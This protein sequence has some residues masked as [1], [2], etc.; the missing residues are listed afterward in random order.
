MNGPGGCE[1]CDA[2]E[3]SLYTALAA[4]QAELPH[5]D[6]GNIGGGD[7]KDGKK[8]PKYKYADL[9]DVS[10]AVLPLL[11]KHG[12]AFN[13]KPTMVDGEFGLSYKLV[14]KSGE[15]DEGFVPF[16]RTGSPQQT[17]SLI[18][19]YR[20]YC[21]C[22]IT[23][24]APDADDDGA[25][26]EAGHQ[27]SAADA[28]ENAAPALPDGNGN[29]T[30]RG[31]VARQPAQAEP[32][33]GDE[34][35]NDAQALANDAH[36]CRSITELAQ[37]I[38][39]TA[40]QRQKLTAFIADPATGTKGQLGP[41]LNFRKKVLADLDAAWKE[42]NVAAGK[43]R[44]NIAEL[45]SELKIKTGVDIEAATSAQIREFIASLDGAA[46]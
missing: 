21:L 24:A 22:A 38:Y 1:V 16:G 43:H 13:S 5:I 28:F 40:H 39:V 29:G 10:Q 44:T 26:A 37:R 2:G 32:K 25:A 41:Y 9:A 3:A 45:E 7:T 8:G 23:G 31:Q 46:A 36:A 14:H 12:L 20:R 34:I 35:D 19:Y 4:V 17:G 11:A 27:Q 18:T 6:K 15:K 33:P 30:P 42:L